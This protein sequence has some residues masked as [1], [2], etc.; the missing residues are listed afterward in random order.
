MLRNFFLNSNNMSY[1]IMQAI[2]PRM[3]AAL[4]ASPASSTPA[5]R[6]PASRSPASRTPASSTPA[7]RSPASS[8]PAPKSVWGPRGWRWLHNLAISFPRR[9]TTVDR[10]VAARRVY[11]F[12]GRLPCQECRKHSS[13]YLDSYPPDLTDTH[14]FQ[15]WVW[16][17]HND[18]NRRLGKPLFPFSAYQQMYLSEMCWASQ[19]V[20][21]SKAFD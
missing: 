10:H 11:E 1:T 18:V 6:T 19:P 9:P 3:R 20:D 16:T 15:V 7:S 13:V 14:T 5:S 4:A 12:I 21:C 17:F 8:T 2:V